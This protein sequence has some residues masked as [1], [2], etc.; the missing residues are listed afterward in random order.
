MRQLTPGA[1]VTALDGLRGILALVVVAAHMGWPFGVHALTEL[2]RI[3]VLTFFVISGYVLT[4]SYDGRVW[5]FLL[6][7]FV[8]LWPLYATTIATGYL[9]TGALPPV[10]ELFW[11]PMLLDH[12]P[13]ID[14]PAWTLYM[15]A[16]VTP[17]LPILFWM[18]ARHRGLFLI[19]PLFALGL[20]FIDVRL[21]FVAFFAAG[22][23]AAQ[24]AIPWPTRVPAIA[25]WL[26]K[27]SYSL[28]LTHFIVLFWAN[29]LFG[30]FGTMVG[31]PA[32]FV[33]A[34]AMWRW[35]EQPSILMSRRI[36]QKCARN[37]S[38]IPAYQFVR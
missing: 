8:R 33:V 3:P 22:V 31:L 19:V 6:R 12:S 34:W 14:P 13:P 18:A 10:G 28:Y 23:A 9:L 20:V 17:I 7:R 27:I 30:S 37:R 11:W 16:W 36:G 15:E 29:K 1:R 32:A 24:F 4:G 21:Y 5:V 26:G 25:I 2:P 35:V 38:P